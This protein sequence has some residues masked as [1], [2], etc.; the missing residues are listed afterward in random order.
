MPSGRQD[1]RKDP[2]TPHGGG[3][4]KQ[5]GLT[6]IEVLIALML[7][8]IGL[9]GIASLQ[10]RAMGANR[11]A[12]MQTEA[13]ALA[14]GFLER[15][16]L[17]PFDHSYLD[18]DAGPRQMIPGAGSTFSV[19]WTVIDDQPVVGNKTIRLRVDWPDAPY[20]SIVRLQTI[21]TR[22]TR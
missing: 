11:A 8:S 20:G 18:S 13:T 10:A 9:L 22:H 21:K 7:V 12:R 16:H 6:L 5:A 17:L 14:A 15:L 2:R 3:Q 1:S 19:R 4:G